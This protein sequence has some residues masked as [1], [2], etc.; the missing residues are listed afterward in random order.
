MLVLNTWFIWGLMFTSLIRL[1][2][3]ALFLETPQIIDI[4]PGKVRAARNLK[5]CVL[6]CSREQLFINSC[7]ERGDFSNTELLNYCYF[8]SHTGGGGGGGGGG[9]MEGK[10]GVLQ[11]WK[12]WSNQLSLLHRLNLFSHGFMVSHILFVRK[13]FKFIFKMVKS[14]KGEKWYNHSL[15]YFLW[16]AISRHASN[17]LRPSFKQKN[18][19]ITA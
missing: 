10:I 14:V 17:C 18:Q 6:P 12:Y 2:R 8:S 9:G 3:F 5:V 15:K 16:K 19:P 11:Y 1:G 13:L 7:G 4:S